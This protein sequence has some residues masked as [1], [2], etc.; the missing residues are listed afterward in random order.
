ME[1]TTTMYRSSIP[2]PFLKKMGIAVGHTAYSHH[3]LW[4]DPLLWYQYGR[5]GRP[6]GKTRLLG[7]TPCYIWYL[8]HRPPHER[9]TTEWMARIRCLNRSRTLCADLVVSLGRRAQRLVQTM[10]AHLA[11]S[12][13]KTPIAICDKSGLKVVLY[14]GLDFQNVAFPKPLAGLKWV[15][16]CIMSGC[17]TWWSPDDRMIGQF[18][19]IWYML[20]CHPF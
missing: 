13:P 18:V 3:Y 4:C 9:E 7:R 10:K 2:L 15:S 16:F 12:E 19:L 5:R 17:L 14:F 11:P 20:Y 8:I 6:R 1:F